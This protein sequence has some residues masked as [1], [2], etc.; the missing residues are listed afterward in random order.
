M[1]KGEFMSSFP[2]LLS[3]FACFGQ[4][5][6][7]QGTNARDFVLPN[8]HQGWVVIEHGVEDADTPSSVDGRTMIRVLASGQVQLSTPYASGILDD[9][10][11]FADGSMA[12]TLS[13]E[14][15]SRTA[16]HAATRATPFI[17]CGGTRTYENI[18]IGAPKR[19]FEY[20]YVGKGPAGDSPSIP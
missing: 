9:R 18:S 17:C 16:E 1:V 3:L 5:G 11:R 10:Y 4:S 2:F 6:S 19:F 15:L 20:F 8:G 13:G 14:R 12:P 7:E